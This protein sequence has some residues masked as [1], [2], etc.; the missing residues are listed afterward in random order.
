MADAGNLKNLET[1]TRLNRPTHLYC[2][3]TLKIF[4]EENQNR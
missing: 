3:E 4:A 1:S 2:E